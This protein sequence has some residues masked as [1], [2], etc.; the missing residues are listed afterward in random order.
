M[1]RRSGIGCT[2]KR[3]TSVPSA[4]A[5]T[6]N[7]ARPRS[8]PTNP[9]LSSAGRGTV[10]ALGVQ[11]GGLDVEADIPAGAVAAD[12]WRTGPWHAARPPAARCRGR[13]GRPGGAAAAA[14]GCR[15]ARGSRRWSAGSRERGWP[16]PTRINEGAALAVAC[17]GAGSCRDSALCVCASGSRPGG[18]CAC[19]PWRRGRRKVPDQGRPRPPRTPGL[20]H[21][22]PPRRGRWPGPWSCRLERRRPC[23]RPLAPLL[24]S[25]KRVDQVEARPRDLDLGSARLAAR[26]WA[27]SRRAWL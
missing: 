4:V 10:A 12:R 3:P 19:R 7:A 20:T 25:V 16:S 21:L 8:T 18:P 15:R 9:P 27:T 6:A 13:G 24:P 14:G 1:P 2:A 26:A 22:S 17:C 5:A 11:V 23:N